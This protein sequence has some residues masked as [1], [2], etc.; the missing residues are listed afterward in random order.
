MKQKGNILY[1]ILFGVLMVFLFLGLVQEQFHVFKI[2]KLE[3]VTLKTEKPKL[4]FDDYVSGKFQSQ[5]EKYVA[6]NFGFRE[7]VI[8]VYNQ[9]VWTFFNKTYCHFIKPGKDGYLFYSEAVND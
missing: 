3:G 1:G 9:Y 8:R 6:E 7:P 5:T 4:T 2:P